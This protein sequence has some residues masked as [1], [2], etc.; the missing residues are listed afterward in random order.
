GRLEVERG[1]SGIA[2][3]EKRFFNHNDFLIGVWGYVQWDWK[4][5]AP[6]MFSYIR[7]RLDVSRCIRAF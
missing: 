3:R 2:V 5:S 7:M 6:N 1:R 4:F